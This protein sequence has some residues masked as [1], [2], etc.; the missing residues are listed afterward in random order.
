MA[1]HLEAC[2]LQLMSTANMY[3]HVLVGTIFFGTAA[4]TI[5]FVGIPWAL[6]S[7]HVLPRAVAVLAA[8]L[9]IIATA[10]LSLPSERNEIRSACAFIAANPNGNADRLSARDLVNIERYCGHDVLT[11]ILGHSGP[12]KDKT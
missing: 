11:R 5:C 1:K 7:Q 12:S 8:C 3:F 2:M 10:V 9:G 6:R 4:V